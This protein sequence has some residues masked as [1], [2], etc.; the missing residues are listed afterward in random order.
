MFVCL[1]K[2]AC[3]RR[4]L[5]ICYFCVHGRVAYNAVILCFDT[6]CYNAKYINIHAQL[7]VR[8]IWSHCSPAV[9]WQDNGCSIEPEKEPASPLQPGLWHCTNQ[10]NVASRWAHVHT[11]RM[12]ANTHVLYS[13][14]GVV[15]HPIKTSQVFSCYVINNQQSLLCPHKWGVF[16]ASWILCQFHLFFFIHRNGLAVN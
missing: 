2:C 1:W 14:G 10:L 12:S 7:A 16:L 3:W 13:Q 6:N 15:W 8:K 9:L 5:W 11:Q 4:T